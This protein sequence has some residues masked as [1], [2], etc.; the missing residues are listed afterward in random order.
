MGFR[1]VIKLFV[2]GY[3]EVGYGNQGS[4][5]FSGINYAF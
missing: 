2:V 3:V 5:V 1:T 4:A